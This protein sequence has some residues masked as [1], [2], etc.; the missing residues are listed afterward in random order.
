MKNLHTEFLRTD[1]G[2]EVYDSWYLEHARHNFEERDFIQKHFPFYENVLQLSKNDIILDAGCGIGSY[3]L[4]FARRGYNVVG[5]DVS[6]NFLSEAKKITQNEGLEIEY[7]LSDYNEMSFGE[8]FSVVF[9]EGSFFYQS[10]EGLVSLLYRIRKA[11]TTDGR[12]YFVHSNPIFRK[13]QFPFENRSEIKKNVIVI[14]KGEYDE[15]EG[16]ERCVWMKIDHETHKHYK[17]D[18]FNMHLPPEKLKGCFLEAGFTDFHFYKKREI[19]DFDPE[20]D[21]GFSVVL[22]K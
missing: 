2:H 4:E 9:F 12:A 7:I 18:Y 17:C 11:L 8:R 20:K 16:G 1:F 3:T 19:G 21:A 10:K 14:E 22:I 13:Q 5:M 15:N 6:P